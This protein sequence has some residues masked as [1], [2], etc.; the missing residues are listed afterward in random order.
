MEAP[1]SNEMLEILIMVTI[2]TQCIHLVTV[3]PVSKRS[4]M[5]PRSWNNTAQFDLKGA[6]SA[7]IAQNSILCGYV[8]P[9]V[10]NVM[11]SVMSSMKSPLW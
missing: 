2:R 3:C 10:G 8:T 5:V 6:E 4:H 11:I 9:P 1:Q 7:D